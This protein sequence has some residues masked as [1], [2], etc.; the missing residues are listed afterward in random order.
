MILPQYFIPKGICLIIPVKWKAYLRKC[1]TLLQIPI[2]TTKIFV[3]AWAHAICPVF[4][5]ADVHAEGAHNI[6]IKFCYKWILNCNEV[7]GCVWYEK[8]QEQIEDIMN[9]IMTFRSQDDTHAS[10]LSGVWT[11]II[12]YRK[13][14][15]P[16]KD[17]RISQA[18]YWPKI[19]W[20]M[21]LNKRNT[22]QSKQWKSHQFSTVSLTSSS[23]CRSFKFSTAIFTDIALRKSRL[24]FL[25]QWSVFEPPEALPIHTLS[26]LP[27]LIHEL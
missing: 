18:V 3:T 24:L 19:N 14:S 15:R 27:Y 9:K 17:G 10:R 20:Y 26:M 23:C 6:N 2:F 5:T 21:I 25:I 12:P 16:T 4:C 8:K 1:A 22:W 11:V 13:T 7:Y